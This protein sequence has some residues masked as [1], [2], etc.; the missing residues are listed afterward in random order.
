MLDNTMEF[1]FEEVHE[2]AVKIKVVGVGGGG[3][4]AVNRMISAYIRGVEFIAINTDAQ[5]LEHSSASKKLIIGSKI[6][7][8]KGAGANPEIGKRAA[9]ESIDE[10]K[11]ILS[12]A[13]MLFITAG[14][15]GGTGT[16]AAPVIA[17]IARELDILT[18]G[19]V[20]KPFSFEGKKRAQ[21][22]EVGIAELAKYVDS[23]IVI[24]NE[25][26][27]EIGD[28]KLTLANAFEIADD[29]LR[30]GVQSVSELINVPGFVN[31]DFADVTTIMK[32]AGYAH[33]GTGSA[34][35]ED[36]AQLAAS[37]AISSPL[38][39]TNIEGATGVL[40]AITASENITLDEIELASNLIYKEAHPDAT[41][42][43]GASFN[44]ELQ[45]EIRITIIATGFIDPKTKK[46]GE[47]V[48][49]LGEIEGNV[50]DFADNAPTP[51]PTANE[52]PAA[53][54]R[55]EAPKVVH[56]DSSKKTLET[57]ESLTE[58]YDEIFTFISRKR[59]D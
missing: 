5:V 8:G 4:N 23:L 42:I 34:K 57:F 52:E 54:P 27:K 21:Q 38:L 49:S 36:K 50:S 58:E 29:V 12:G 39:E 7:S 19:I 6:T 37:S 28:N 53:E 46:N 48:R 55:P 25:R 24:P 22:A 18:I 56:I 26:L 10:I 14:M 11:S 30:R 47:S 13:D 20:T 2:S 43:W 33:M 32:G 51:E 17:R 41:I 45:D 16:G 1:D 15:G 35:G 3:N 9:E 31:L 44:P 59:K 40:I